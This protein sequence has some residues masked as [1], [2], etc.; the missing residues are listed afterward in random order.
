[1]LEPVI[2]QYTVPL[3]ELAEGTNAVQ[4]PPTQY[5]LRR[6]RC[7]SS[8]SLQVPCNIP[9]VQLREHLRYCIDLSGVYPHRAVCSWSRAICGGLAR[10]PPIYKEGDNG[11]HNDLRYVD[12]L[13]CHVGS[14]QY[15]TGQR[16]RRADLRGGGLLGTG[17]CGPNFAANLT[18]RELPKDSTPKNSKS[19]QCKLRSKEKSVVRSEG[20]KFLPRC[21]RGTSKRR[22]SLA[23]GIDP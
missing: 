19:T 5:P 7:I 18:G 1:M 6:G 9:S 4:R 11:E 17:D 20:G 12:A 16:V 23:P 13:L 3:S 14:M 21:C 8:V 2:C 10:I 15:D 22:L